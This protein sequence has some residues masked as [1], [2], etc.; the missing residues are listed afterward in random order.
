MVAWVALLSWNGTKA[1]DDIRAADR[2]GRL[3]SCRVLNKD[4]AAIR[5]S[6]IGFGELLVASSPPDPTATP[7]EVI[8][9]DALVAAFRERIRQ[10]TAELAVPIPCSSFVDDPEKYLT[11]GPPSGP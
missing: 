6:Q 4:R 8:E 10:Q 9:R 11:D 5:A 3:V 7:A 2:A 1:D